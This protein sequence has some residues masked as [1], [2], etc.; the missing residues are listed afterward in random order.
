MWGTIASVAAPVLGGLLGYAGQEETNRTNAQ[1][2]NATNQSNQLNAREQMAFQERMSNTAHSRA[3]KDLKSAGLNPI[4]AATNGASTPGGA[5]GTS[6]AAQMGNSIQAGLTG[7]IEA[8]RLQ[9]EMKMQEQNIAES[10]SRTTNQAYDAKLK[11][12]QEK[13]LRKDIP[14]SEMI[15]EVYDIFKP[16]IRGVK[17]LIQGSPKHDPKNTPAKRLEDKIL[18]L[19][20]P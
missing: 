7:A 14:K 11:D 19:N 16:V 15:N 9:N 5:A 1:I 8:K 12:T 6:T 18:Q 20:K 13:V 10:I 4:L 2:A 17:G 3:V